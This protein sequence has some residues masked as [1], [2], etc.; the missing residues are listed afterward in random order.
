MVTIHDV[1]FAPELGSRNP[2]AKRREL[3][4]ALVR[5]RDQ[6][7]YDRLVHSSR[8]VLTLTL[9]TLPAC[10]ATRSTGVP[11]A[12][13]DFD[14][15]TSTKK[16][17]ATAPPA[18]GPTAAECSA[19]EAQNGICGPN[20][21]EVSVNGSSWVASGRCTFDCTKPGACS[22]VTCP[23][24]VYCSFGCGGDAGSSCS[25]PALGCGAANSCGTITTQ[26]AGSLGQI[27]GSGL[28]CEDLTCNGTVCQVACRTVADAGGADAAGCAGTL[29]GDGGACCKGFVCAGSGL[30][31]AVP[32]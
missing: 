28:G 11:D 10:G 24:N 4:N 6:L 20:A 31:A 27:L 25:D 29:C 26:A 13:F 7:A 2:R 18:A 14:A 8:L 32:K 21:R 9:A 22:N 19:C 16:D 15:S 1:I 17:V 3:S 5:S 12:S 30:C 23:E